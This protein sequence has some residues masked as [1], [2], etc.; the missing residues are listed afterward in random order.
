MGM[1]DNTVPSYRHQSFIVVC[2]ITLLGLVVLLQQTIDQRGDED[3]ER[4]EQLRLLPRGEILK[5]TLLGYH[6]LGADLIWLRAIQV[7]GDKVVRDQDY[8]WLY[9]ALDVVT[10]LDPQY[11]YAYDVGG[12]VL[13]ELAGR[14]DLSNQILEKG[15]KP[16]PPSWRLPF[17]LGF[18]HFF[19]LG[20]PRQAADYM[21]RAA[22]ARGML[23][24]GPP[25][26]YIPRLASR[27]YAQ[28]KSPE[29]AI[30]FLEAMLLQTT[31]PLIREQLQRRIR[32]V[33]LE[34]DL[35]MIEG[36]V[37]R[38]EQAQRKKPSSLDELVASGL[39]RTIPEEPYGGRY[40]F[41]TATGEVFSSTHTERMRAYRQSDS[42]V[43]K[44]DV[45]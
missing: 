41:N 2:L 14:Y 40:L 12:T 7:L 43:R 37:Q 45:E 26:P 27:L 30:E 10:T 4:I 39:L 31:E 8:Q 1:T 29:V 38:Y 5:P 34:R 21:A 42:M 28:G 3:K 13:A 11:L 17:L 16:N 44:G 15:L 19:H 22:G 6:H 18:N 25:P 23:H 36:A 35:Q 33:G 9:H 24:E 20:Q 32:R